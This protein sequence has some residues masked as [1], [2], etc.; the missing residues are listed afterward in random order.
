MEKLTGHSEQSSKGRTLPPNDPN[1]VYREADKQLFNFLQANNAPN[2]ACY[3]L[4]SPQMGKS[5]LMVK[6]TS[7]LSKHRYICILIELK[8]NASILS[9]DLFYFNLLKIIYKRIK[10]NNYQ[11][12]QELNTFWQKNLDVAPV[13]KFKILIGKLLGIIGNKRLIVFIDEIQKLIDWQLQES[14]ANLIKT[15]A[16]SPEAHQQQLTFVLLGTANPAYLLPEASK[17]ISRVSLIQ[18]GNFPKNCPQLLPRLQKVSKNPANLWQEILLWTGGQPFLTMSLWDLVAKRLKAYNDSEL[19]TQIEQLVNSEF[20]QPGNQPALQYHCQRI[21]NLFIRGDPDKIDSKILALNLYEKILRNSTDRQISD[22]ILERN[23]VS[24][25]EDTEIS[26]FSP[27]ETSFLTEALGEKNLLTSGL[28]AKYDK[29]IKVANP[30]YQQIFNKKWVEQTKQLVIQRRCYMA[31]PKI[32]NRDVFLLIDQSGSMVRKDQA[33]G[34]KIRWKFLPEPLEGH[35]YRILNE[36]GL[37]G[38]KI[39]EEIVATCFSPNRVNKKTSYITSPS[40]IETFFIENQPATSTYLVPTLD[41]LLSQ[42]FATRNQRGGFFII[43]TDGQIDDRDEFVKLIEATS[44][45][46]NSQD[47]LKIVIIGIG[48]D[49]DPKFYIQLDQNTKAFKDAKGLDCNIVVFDLLNEVEDIIDLLDRQLEDPEGGMPTWAK[50][51]Y[52]ELFA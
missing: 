12:L 50:E 29:I 9:E 51:Q 42:W 6:T 26:A 28:V 23:P 18:L 15:L 22:R 34:N 47:D 13:K 8:T 20:L 4:A 46:L 48:S 37:D 41:H 17:D 52:P 33:T 19:K 30:I 3:I 21:E 32:F 1:Y 25:E 43:Y 11:L 2:L 36:T 7:K 44:R 35:V 45:K 5:S 24:R 38:Q 10:R 31:S 16:V 14:F 39:C 40:Q 49:I 27:K